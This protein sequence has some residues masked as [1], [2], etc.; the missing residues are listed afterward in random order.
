LVISGDHLGGFFPPISRQKASRKPRRLK[1]MTNLVSTLHRTQNSP[2]A[3]M[4][5]AHPS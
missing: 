2:W 4:T 1:S 3:V 5:I